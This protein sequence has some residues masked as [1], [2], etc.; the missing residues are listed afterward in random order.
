MYSTHAMFVQR[1]GIIPIGRHRGFCVPKKRKEHGLTSSIKTT[2]CPA[3]DH[4]QT[5]LSAVDC[6]K[7][8][9]VMWLNSDC[10]VASQPQS[11]TR[12]LAGSSCSQLRSGMFVDGGAVLRWS[13]RKRY[14]KRF[15]WRTFVCKKQKHILWVW[16]KLSE[17]VT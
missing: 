11:C 7:S 12:C 8:S 17:N 16:S 14:G 6:T 4:R 13:I 10:R 15:D 9:I 3:N 1:V 2:I 5:L